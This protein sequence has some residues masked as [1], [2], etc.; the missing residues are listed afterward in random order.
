[1]GVLERENDAES[2]VM[3]C[4]EGRCIRRVEG[5]GELS[6]RC[7]HD[8]STV[9]GGRANDVYGPVSDSSDG[10]GAPASSGGGAT[11]IGFISLGLVKS[12]RSGRENSSWIRSN[13]PRRF[14]A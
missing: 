9:N 2:G 12:S 6:E 5:G 10:L 4:R 13:P 7:D 3:G 1:V 8:G 11:S 14:T